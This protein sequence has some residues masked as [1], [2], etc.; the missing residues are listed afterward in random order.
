M[1]SFFAATKKRVTGFSLAILSLN[2]VVSSVLVGLTPMA[3]YAAGEPCNG[4]TFDS[5]IDG[6]VNG[7]GGWKVTG[8]YDQAVV[9]NTYGY[10]TFGCKTFRLSNAVTSSH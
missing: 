5:F 2:I 10:S 7:Q 3:V 4:S 8:P 6:S 9:P 1:N